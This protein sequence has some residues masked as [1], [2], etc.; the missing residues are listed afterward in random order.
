MYKIFFFFY[1]GILNNEKS[2]LNDKGNRS[3]QHIL[4]QAFVFIQETSS[5]RTDTRQGKAK[6]HLLWLKHQIF[7]FLQKETKNRHFYLYSTLFYQKIRK[8]LVL[9]EK[10]FLNML[11]K[12]KKHTN[13]AYKLENKSLICIIL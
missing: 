1:S 2:Q 13:A 3:K 8:I 11:Y 5:G 10:C 12:N 6:I 7:Q 9:M 4:F